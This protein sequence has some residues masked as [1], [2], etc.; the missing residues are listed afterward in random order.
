MRLVG[1]IM[2]TLLV[3]CLCYNLLGLTKSEMAKT[4]R[5]HFFV[6]TEIGNY[7]ELI[8]LVQ[9]GGRHMLLEDEHVMLL[10]KN[11]ELVL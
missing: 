9:V 11:D 5:F 7:L 4:S 6:Q 1:Y 2:R 8:L 10:V 3:L